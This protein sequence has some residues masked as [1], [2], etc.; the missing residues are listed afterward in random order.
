MKPVRIK[1]IKSKGLKLYSNKLS[2]D[3]PN[4][5]F[6]ILVSQL[7]K[8]VNKMLSVNRKE[9]NWEISVITRIAKIVIEA[10][11]PYLKRAL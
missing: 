7:S 6:N 5:N 2:F 4:D 1:I 11:A 10:K 9:S 8:K 3:K